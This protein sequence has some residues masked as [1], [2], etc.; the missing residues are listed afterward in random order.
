MRA[1]ITFSECEHDDDLSNYTDDVRKSGGVIVAADLDFDTE[2]GFVTL[3]FPD[4]V[5]FL[6]AFRLTDSFQFSNLNR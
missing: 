5:K 6:D 1:R 4:K 2:E 3:D